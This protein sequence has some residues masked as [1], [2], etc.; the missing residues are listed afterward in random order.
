MAAEAKTC[1]RCLRGPSFHGKHERTDPQCVLHNTEAATGGEVLAYLRSQKH[2]GQKGGWTGPQQT[3]LKSI[4][5]TSASLTTPPKKKTP[6]PGGTGEEHLRG[7]ARCHKSKR[8][9]SR[10]S[11]TSTTG[12][13]ILP[14]ATSASHTGGATTIQGTLDAE[15]DGDPFHG[16][17]DAAINNIIHCEPP[18]SK[19]CKRRKKRQKREENTKGPSVP[20]RGSVPPPAAIPRGVLKGLSPLEAG[21]ARAIPQRQQAVERMQLVPARHPATQAKE[22]TGDADNQEIEAY[23]TIPQQHSQGDTNDQANETY[24]TNSGLSPLEAGAAGAIPPRQ[25]AVERMQMVPAG[26]PATQ[27]KEET[28][29]A[30]NQE[31]EAYSTIPQQHSQGDTDDQANQTYGTNSG[32]GD[33]NVGCQ[34]KPQLV[35]PQDSPA[36]GASS[37][38]GCL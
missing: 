19:K 25:Q 26:H 1:L 15:D 27:A 36:S 23:S 28:G 3:R 2:S 37:L 5:T 10:S 8:S 29:D 13:R 22:E 9:S 21:A 18:G 24:G 38:P 35:P 33:V 14:E 6:P 12:P 4:A 31:I 7:K 20:T 16:D 30:D 11:S 34:H 17:V 32:L